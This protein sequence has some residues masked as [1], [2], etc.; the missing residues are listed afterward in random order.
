MFAYATWH[1]PPVVRRDSHIETLADL[2]GRRYA[3]S[4]PGSAAALMHHALMN[5]AGLDDHIRW[6]YGS[7][8][9]IYDAFTS[10]RVDV[11]PGVITNDAISPRL[12]EA[13]ALVDVVPLEIPA[14]VMKR[15]QE[16]NAGIFAATKGPEAWSAI[17]A[18]TVFP[19]S[20][21][22]LAAAPD[23]TA[24]VGYEITK[25][26][27]DDAERIRSLGVALRY[28]DAEFALRGLMAAF[29]VNAGALSYFHENGIRN[30][31]LTIVADP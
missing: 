11:V 20:I 29:P 18:P 3:P 27:Y 15:A 10:K 30:D 26:I 5:A 6:T 28:V 8:T 7:W 16:I 31:A 19:Y 4:T 14:A 25:A 21:G 12:I 24:E 9:E 22:V 2:R 17:E 1:M 23:T 13:Q